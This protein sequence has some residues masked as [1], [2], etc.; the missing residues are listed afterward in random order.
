MERRLLQ[1]SANLQ[2]N[3][4]CTNPLGAVQRIVSNKLALGGNKSKQAARVGLFGRS[5][6]TE[7]RHF[8]GSRSLEVEVEGV[9]AL[10]E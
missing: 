7:L 6:F 5:R 9:L 10:G 4:K 1:S 2:K 8:Q 3:K